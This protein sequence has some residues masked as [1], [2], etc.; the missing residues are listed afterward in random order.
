MTR[1]GQARRAGIRRRARARCGALVRHSRRNGPTDT[2]AGPRRCGSLVCHSGTV[3]KG[4]PRFLVTGPSRRRAGRVGVAWIR[5]RARAGPPLD[6]G[7]SCVTPGRHSEGNH[8]FH[9]PGQRRWRAGQAG[10]AGIRRRAR[11]RRGALV[12]HSRRTGPTDTQAG[13]RWCGSLVR[14]SWTV[15]KGQPRF[16]VPGPSRRRAGRVGVAGI[17]R[18][19]LIK[20]KL[21][22]LLPCII[23][24]SPSL[25]VVI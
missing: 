20:E 25:D 8:S 12:R 17:R 24:E 14:H 23:I 10:R 18:R 15:S 5:R 4:Q 16:Q 19:I 3:S 1:A 11:A 7:R 13:P 21:R 9:G 2:Q 6:A 22:F